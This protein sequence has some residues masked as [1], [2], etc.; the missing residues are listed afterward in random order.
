[1]LFRSSSKGPGDMDE[2]GEEHGGTNPDEKNACH[3][4]HTVVSAGNT[5]DWPHSFG[6]QAR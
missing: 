5:A 6:W 3:V 1:M 2:F 4:C